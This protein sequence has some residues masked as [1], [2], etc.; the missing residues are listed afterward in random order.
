MRHELNR[1]Q[2]LASAK[3]DNGLGTGHVHSQ[4]VDDDA[5]HRCAQKSKRQFRCQRSENI[6]DKLMVLD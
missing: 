6:V 1:K 5:F 3:G 4:R 2:S